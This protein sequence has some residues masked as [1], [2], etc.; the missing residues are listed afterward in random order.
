M[1]PPGC[2]LYR[3]YAENAT[4]GLHVD[5]VAEAHRFRSGFSFAIQARDRGKGAGVAKTGGLQINQDL[6]FQRRE[7]KV[8]HAGWWVLTAF[9]LAAAA[10]LFGNGP[11]SHARVGD[12]AR[13]SVDYERFTRV[14]THTRVVVHG[15][16]P[17]ADR[18]VELSLD[19]DYFESLRIVRITPEPQG[20]AF[21]ENAVTLRFNRE[22]GRASGYT[23]ILDVEPLHAG[24]RS[25]TLTAANG[26]SV[27]WRQFAYF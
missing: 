18:A 26:T 5:G 6:E 3:R 21:A 20:I 10:G 23:I 8:Q 15:A 2:L 22:G 13:L 12:P 4:H 9:V 17:A 1:Q 25:A 24:R 7:W 14:G 19:R 27:V 11:V 16:Q